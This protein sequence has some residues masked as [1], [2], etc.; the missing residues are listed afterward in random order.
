M[1]MRAL[2][3]WTA[4]AGLYL[5]VVP[6]RAAID[7]DG[8]GD[9]STSRPAEPSPDISSPDISSPD[10]S[11]PDISSP[12]SLVPPAYLALVDEPRSVYPEIMPS[13]EGAFNNSGGVNFGLDIDWLNKYVYRGINQSTLGR[14]PENA[15]Q[16]N[17]QAH[18][19]LGKFP[20]PFIGLFV[21]VF[22][23]D[24]VSRFEEV[25]PYFGLEWIIKPITI[26]TGYT[27]YIYPNRKSAARQSVDTQEVF[28]QIQLDDSRLFHTAQPLL[29]PYIYGA[30]D[31]SLYNGFYLEAGLR[32]D[33][34]F[35]DYG[36][37]FSP[38]AKIAYVINDPYFA[39]APQ[40]RQ[41]GL[42]HY[43]VGAI[44]NVSINHF[45]KVDHRYGEWSINGY[46]YYTGRIDPELRADTVVWGGVGLQFRY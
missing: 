1:R 36:L 20:H 19:D 30:Y 38:L 15:L 37:T 27:S 45:F 2:A 46:L 8:F 13:Q 42:Q 23:S 18:F 14:K 31:F 16:F 24:P 33:F 6:A 26:T 10:I 29:S 32:H 17:A 11:S 40:T 39:L 35:E 34:V 44:G 22:N 5:G 9:L 25:R 7:L 12:D 4:L 41:H 43:D 21:N 3:I 28:T